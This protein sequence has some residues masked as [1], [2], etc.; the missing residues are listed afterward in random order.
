M[1]DKL[2]KLEEEYRALEG[3]LGDPEVL[4]DAAR[5]R[6]KSR[7]YAEL[8]EVIQ[9]FRE[10]QRVQDELEQARE[11]AAD[12]EL[13]EMAREEAAELE[14]RLAGLEKKLELLLLPRDPADVRN[15]IVEIRAGTGGQ[16]AALFAGDLFEMYTRYA[17]R[18]G[19]QVEML[20]S[21]PTDLGGFSK[22]SFMVKGDGAYGVFKYE[23]GV[24]RVQ[25]VPATETQGRI[26]TSTATVAV[27][28]EAEESDV[29]LDMS[30][31]RIDVMRASG[32]GG[33]GVNTTDSAVRVVHEPTGIIITIQ[34]SR[35]QIKNREKALSILRSRLLEMKRAEEEAALRSNRLAQIGSGERSEKIRT[36][37][38]P[39]SRVTDHRIHFTTHNLEGV[40]AGELDELTE[41]L[42]K[43][44]QERM[45]EELSGQAQNA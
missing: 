41:A 16:E 21:H 3:E 6:E 5:F 43:A 14:A 2:K 8:G 10:F 28:P 39:Q 40:L 24:H 23:S 31:V 22:V 9:T 44:D 37:N 45:L 27:L 15:A 12:P 34:D 11:L 26:H 35:S 30:E 25:R 13:G 17:E 36:Y 4:A 32:P 42:K 19:Y 29:E 7:R 20:E 38:F 1:L 18:L 33:Q